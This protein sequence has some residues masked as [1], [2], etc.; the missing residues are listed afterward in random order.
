MEPIPQ[1]PDNDMCAPFATIPKLTLIDDSKLQIKTWYKPLSKCDAEQSE[2]TSVRI[3]PDR[4]GLVVGKLSADIRPVVFASKRRNIYLWI[5]VNVQPGEEIVLASQLNQLLQW[6]EL[7]VNRHQVFISALVI[8]HNSTLSEQS[9]S[10]VQVSNILNAMVSTSIS[11]EVAHPALID[12]MYRFAAPHTEHID[13]V[14]H[15]LIVLHKMS[16]MRLRAEGRS[17]VF[18]KDI[19]ELA[20][21]WLNYPFCAAN[22][23]DL[24]VQLFAPKQSQ[25]F[26]REGSVS[27]SR[28]GSFAFRGGP[29]LK[30]LDQLLPKAALLDP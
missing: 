21:A 18:S 29:Y 28:V 16:T 10:F 20:F 11:I 30:L 14:T 15:R 27:V 8:D 12:H 4:S 19:S 25:N 13:T 1:I 9:R 26:L 24:L 6:D 7:F 22:V 5:A 2:S 23:R 3:Q 17:L